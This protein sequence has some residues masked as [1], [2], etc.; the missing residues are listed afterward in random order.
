MLFLKDRTRAGLFVS[1]GLL[2][3]TVSFTLLLLALPGIG[4]P[5]F[6]V[7]AIAC[8]LAFV[9]LIYLCVDL[10][11]TAISGTPAGDFSFLWR[12]SPIASF[13]LTSFVLTVYGAVFLHVLRSA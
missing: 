3:Q 4:V 2:I 1:G 5:P 8:A 10:G 12:I 7:T 11:F 13:A 9:P 6:W